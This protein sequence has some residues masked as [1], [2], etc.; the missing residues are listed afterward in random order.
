MR[1]VEEDGCD[2]LA[3]LACVE[4]QLRLRTQAA[5]SFALRQAA[6]R[7]TGALAIAGLLLAMISVAALCTASVKLLAAIIVVAGVVMRASISDP[8]RESAQTGN[9]R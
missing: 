8:R 4:A 9:P 2:R 7:K 5:E 1:G 3:R 6:W